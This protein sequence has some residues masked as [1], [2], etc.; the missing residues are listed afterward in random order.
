MIRTTFIISLLSSSLI[1]SAQNI[2]LQPANSSD[3]QPTQLVSTSIS[4]PSFNNSRDPI[5]FNWPINGTAIPN[6]QSVFVQ[7]SRQYWLDVDHNELATGVNIHTTAPGSIIRISPTTEIIKAAHLETL[8]IYLTTQGNRMAPGQGIENLVDQQALNASGASFSEGTIAF[9]L[10]ESIG[11]GSIHV[12]LPIAATISDQFVIHVFEPNS[13]VTLNLQVNQNNYIAGDDLLANMTLQGIGHRLDTSGI[14][15]YITSPDAKLSIPVRFSDNRN[16]G[17]NTVAKLPKNTDVRHGLWTLHTLVRTQS[18]NGLTIIR[19]AKTAFSITL[20]TARL[21]HQ[22]SLNQRSAAPQGIVS[23]GPKGLHFELGIEAAVAGRYEVSGIL[24]GT[25]K[26]GQSLPI[27][28]AQT[29]QWLNP[30]QGQIKLVFGQDI[31]SDSSLKAPYQVRH[32]TLKDQSRLSLL[33]TRQQGFQ[34]P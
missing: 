14:Q 6:T 8:D 19:D 7:N 27:S 34:I 9:R 30:G 20:P 1:A 25:S 26:T 33:Q 15:G 11:S 23:S 5:Q 17:F 18:T 24:Y 28:M 3:L 22:V 21:N 13:S 4:L 16:G 12:A 10:S 32:L 29:A 2:P 31:L